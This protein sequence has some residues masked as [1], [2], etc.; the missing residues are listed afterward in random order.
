MGIFV[1]GVLVVAGP[2]NFEF[3]MKFITK[4]VWGLIPASVFLGAFTTSAQEAGTLLLREAK[5]D[6][7]TTVA[8]EVYLVDKDVVEVKVIA[9]MYAQKPRIYNV[10]I[11]G[12]RL[13]R[14]SP[15]TRETLP[16]GLEPTEPFP[17][18]ERKGFISF[19]PRE[20]EKQPKGRLTQELLRFKIPLQR[21]IPGKRYQLW[22]KIESMAKGGKI[23]SFKFDIPDFA[24]V[25]SSGGNN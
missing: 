15:L 20:K 11:I 19:G 2:G 12:P 17:T 4:I 6:K 1:P 9:R 25:L 8:V 16:L 22:V 5:Q 14:I 23:H 21:L 24:E 18:K 13:G 7:K 3:V 10:I